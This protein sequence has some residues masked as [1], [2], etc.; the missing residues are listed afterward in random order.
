MVIAIDPGSNQSA[1]VVWSGNKILKLGIVG[2]GILLREVLP[3]VFQ[4]HPGI[5]MVIEEVA[6]YG[7]PV[8]QSTFE[9]VFWTGRF[10][11]AWPGGWVR[12]V[13]MYVKMHVCQDSRAKDSNIR[14]ALID[15]FEPDLK[16]KCRPKEALKGVSK[17]CW[18]ALALAVYYHDTHAEVK[19]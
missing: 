4:E 16:P 8:G 7:M 5:E 17:D 10:C 2:N 1:Y 11:Q 15:R 6:C 3:E 13:R 9:T 14:Q 12:Q 19:E 18:Q